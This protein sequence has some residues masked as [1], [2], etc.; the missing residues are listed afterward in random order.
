MAKLI[1]KQDRQWTCNVILRRV[2]V[3][4]RSGKP[5]L[6]TYAKCVFVNF[7]SLRYPEYKQHV[8]FLSDFNES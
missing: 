5:I 6:V 4:I 3:N 1:Y 2:S 8:F 7:C